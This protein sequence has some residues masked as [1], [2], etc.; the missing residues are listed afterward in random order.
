MGLPVFHIR[1]LRENLCESPMALAIHAISPVEKSSAAMSAMS[2]K[3]APFA[4]M[5]LS[6]SMKIGD[7]PIQR[8]L[9]FQWK[10]IRQNLRGLRSR[11]IR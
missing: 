11:L 7:G 5:R 3:S 10:Q 8:G 4:A 2:A 6:A 9:E 1:G